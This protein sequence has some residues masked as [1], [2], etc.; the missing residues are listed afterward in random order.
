MK[1]QEQH[2][3]FAVK[4]YAK[5]M[6]T[7]Q[8][9]EVFI[10]KFAHELPQS[11]PPPKL[12]DYEKEIEGIDYQFNRDEYVSKQMVV[13]EQRYIS[14]LSNQL[15]RLNIT[16]TQFPEKYRKLFNET[17][18]EFFS[19]QRNQYQPNCENILLELETMYAYVNNLIF[20]EEIPT[21]A[22]KQVNIALNLLKTMASQLQNDE[23][24]QETNTNTQ[25]STPTENSKHKVS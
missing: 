5:Y 20:Q 10:E 22:I 6:K 12:L 19:C 17:R 14:E 15:R 11:P 4:C 18:A 7:S 9:V 8:V 3:E 2:N 25:R 16:H 13:M 23:H 1:L 24:S 21:E